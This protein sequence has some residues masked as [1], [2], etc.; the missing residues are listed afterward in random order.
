M[1][2]LASSFNMGVHDVEMYYKLGLRARSYILMSMHE[3]VLGM[4]ARYATQYRM[5]QQVGTTTTHT[6]HAI[7]IGLARK[8]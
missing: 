1:S 4:A 8:Q 5:D 7:A 6:A 3:V 2:D